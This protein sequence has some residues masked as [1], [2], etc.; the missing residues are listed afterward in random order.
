MKMIQKLFQP[1]PPSLMI[2]AFFWDFNFKT[3]FC[4]S[5]QNLNLVSLTGTWESSSGHCEKH[6]QVH[7]AEATD[8]SATDTPSAATASWGARAETTAL[9]GIGKIP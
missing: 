8:P 2:L 5:N 7:A 1:T 9:D 6:A 4:P 3:Y